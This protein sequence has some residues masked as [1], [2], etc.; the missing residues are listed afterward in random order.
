[1]Q[2]ALALERSPLG[3]RE[4]VYW[5]VREGLEDEPRSRGAV[6]FWLE[7]AGGRVLVR[8]DGMRVEARAERREEVLGRVDDDIHEV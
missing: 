5:D 2:R 1:M 4:C 8:A 3:G 7:D 6:D